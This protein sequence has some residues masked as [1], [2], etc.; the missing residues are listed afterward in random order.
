MKQFVL[1]QV[2]I[3]QNAFLACKDAKSLI[4]KISHFLSLICQP[5]HILFCIEA[6]QFRCLA[7]H[8]SGKP[9]LHLELSPTKLKAQISNDKLWQLAGQKETLSAYLPITYLEIENDHH[10][11]DSWYCLKLQM[12]DKPGIFIFLKNPQKEQMIIWKS[13]QLLASLMMQFFHLLQKFM[14]NQQH[15]KHQSLYQYQH[16]HNRQQQQQHYHTPP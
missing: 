16:Q 7:Q 2:F 5:Q 6:D 1:D 15:K 10:T 13:D 14:L 12:R 3:T 8:E 11:Q 4:T 9:V